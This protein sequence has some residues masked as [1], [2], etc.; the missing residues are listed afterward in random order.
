M[1][2]EK[3]VIREANVDDA[4]LLTELSVTTFRDKFGPLNKQEDMDL[5]IASEMNIE[6]LTA[7][8]ADHDNLFFLAYNDDVATGYVKLRTKDIPNELA[9]TKPIELERLYVRQE[10]QGKKIGAMLLNHCV[11]Y[12]LSKQY[13]TLWLGV[14]EHNDGA[15]RFY[16]R[17][18]FEL[19]GEHPFLLGN[20]AQR[21]VLMRRRLSKGE[22][23][24]E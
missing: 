9:G 18:G 3:I 7:E 10:Y 2:V 5:Y 11:G 8:L 16:E 22:G 23:E 4:A 24:V 21:D 19:F 20:D 1:T 12:A 13:D 17:S 15:I 14:W 6:K